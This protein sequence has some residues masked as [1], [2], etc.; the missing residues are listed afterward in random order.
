VKKIYLVRHGQT[1]FNKLHKVQ[2]SGIDAPLN[3]TGRQQAQA[4]FE[5]YQH[6]PLDHVYTSALQRT[7]QSVQGFI[8]KGLPHTALPELNEISWGIR[9]GQVFTVDGHDEYKQLTQAWKSGNYNAC[10][11]GGESPRQVAAREKV[12]FEHILAQTHEKHILI[13]MHGRAMRV[14]LCQLLNYPLSA[15]DM[16]EHHNLGLYQLHYTGSM[17]IV[18]RYNN[19]AHLPAHLVQTPMGSRQVRVKL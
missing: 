2:G 9:E 16:F 3:H 13:C 10:I 7:H 12:A 11:E 5:Y 14:L 15:M 6:L 18:D 19:T 8:E 4:F 1:E 17:F